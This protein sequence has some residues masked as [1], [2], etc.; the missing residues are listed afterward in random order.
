MPQTA[1]T[2]PVSCLGCQRLG[3]CQEATADKILAS[4]CCDR[5]QAAPEAAYHARLVT[6]SRHGR[7]AAQVL[8]DL[9]RAQQD[10]DNEEDHGAP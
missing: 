9:E 2:N 10:I 5:W 4:Y 6:I 8:V 3:V 7:A 1:T